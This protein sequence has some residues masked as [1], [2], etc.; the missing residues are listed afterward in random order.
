MQVGGWTDQDTLA[1]HREE[2]HPVA[3]DSTCEPQ[4][5]GSSEEAKS[6]D[7]ILMLGSDEDANKE[8]VSITSIVNGRKLV[9]LN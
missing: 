8:Q 5:E 9:V 7:E 6:L 1:D 4:H 2:S 3:V